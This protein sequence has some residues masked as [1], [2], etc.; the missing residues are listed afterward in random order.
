MAFGAAASNLV[1]GGHERDAVTSS[2]TTAERA[3]TERVS[4]DSGGAAGGTTEHSAP[5]SADGRCMAF[6]S[7]ATN[8]VTGDTNGVADVFV[9]DRKLGET[10]RFSVQLRWAE[11]ISGSGAEELGTKSALSRNGRYVAF[12]SSRP[13]RRRPE[14][15]R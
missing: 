13:R 2:S 10:T 5:I 6:E 15:R 11:L 7:P 1:S 14:R 3:T 9:H 12:S 4:V 8:L